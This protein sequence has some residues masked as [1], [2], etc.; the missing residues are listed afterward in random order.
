M[1]DLLAGRVDF[2]FAT[3]PTAFRHIASSKFR[4]LAV[5]TAQRLPAL[6]AVP[7]LQESGYPGFALRSWFGVMA[8]PRT[9]PE[10]VG[11]LNRAIATAMADPE[12]AGLLAEQGETALFSTPEEFR[13]I[14]NAEQALWGPLALAARRA[15]K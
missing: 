3:T 5:P 2:I 10:I 4:A 12:V 1:L 9:P 13:R 6:P 14:G 11:I 7:T 15:Q 8:P